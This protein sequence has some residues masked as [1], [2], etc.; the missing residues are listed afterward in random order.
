MSYSSLFTFVMLLC[1]DLTVS[2]HPPPRFL[3]SSLTHRTCR[4]YVLF[5]SLYIRTLSLPWFH[6]LYYVFI[7]HFYFTLP[8]GLSLGP[9][10][11]HTSHIQSTSWLFPFTTNLPHI[12][13][14]GI[15]TG[16][17]SRGCESCLRR[18][19]CKVWAIVPCRLRKSWTSAERFFYVGPPAVSIM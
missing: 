8:R 6:I 11:P 16:I 13:R 14:T 1:I 3:T 19:P 5:L 4:P 10:V 18:N 2:L 17:N 15:N 12:N 7:S 9:P